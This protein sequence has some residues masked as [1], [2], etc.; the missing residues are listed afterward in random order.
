MRRKKNTVQSALDFFLDSLGRRTHNFQTSNEK[1]GVS[2]FTPYPPLDYYK[3]LEA[4][5]IALPI[6]DWKFYHY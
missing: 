3:I 1:E 4:E 5:G 6:A 2:S